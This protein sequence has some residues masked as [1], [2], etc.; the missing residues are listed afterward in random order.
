MREG[1]PRLVYSTT[2]MRAAFAGDIELVKLLLAHGANPHIPS[3]D[4]E[5]TLMAASGTGFINGNHQSEK[6]SRTAGE[7]IKLLVDLGEDVN[8]ADSYGITPLMVAANLGD[9]NVVKYLVE[10]GADLNT[11][12]LGKKNDGAFRLEASNL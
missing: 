2:I 9:L 4:R 5:T 8:A 1:S 11:H 6:T 7:W 3:S 10:K 12:D